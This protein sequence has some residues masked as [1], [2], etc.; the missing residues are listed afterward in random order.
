MRTFRRGLVEFSGFLG[1]LRRGHPL[2]FAGLILFTFLAVVCAAAG[3]LAPFDPIHQDLPSRRLPPSLT[4]WMGTD[5]LGRDVLSRV[6]YGGR[7]SIAIGILAALVGTGLG[8]M[9]GAVSG[10]V[11]GWV[12]EALM[13]FTDMA[14]SIPGLPVLIVLAAILE[15]SVTGMALIIGALSWMSTARIVR[16][17]VQSIRERPYIDAARTLGL[18]HGLI[19]RRHVIPNAAGAIIVG[20]T[21]AVGD[22]IILESSLS[23]LGLGIQPP[24]ATWGNLLTDAGSTMRTAPW[25]TI[26][27]GLAILLTVLAINYLGDGLR[28][29]LDPTSK[30]S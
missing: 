18:R 8:A 15:P 1:S 16:V 14:Y 28:D 19:L 13:R 21:L 24:T 20:V 6:L 30:S 12:D 7:I 29:A 10:Y 25:L 26:F 2:A 4:H 22:A 9:I 5:D 27:P 11:G 17:E 23:F 3:L